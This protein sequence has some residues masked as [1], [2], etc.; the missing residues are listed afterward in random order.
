MVT[1]PN[2]PGGQRCPGGKL[3]R[4]LLVLPGFA[5]YNIPW[6]EA[7]RPMFSVVSDLAEADNLAITRLLSPSMSRHLSDAGDHG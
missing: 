5:G 4:P 1:D 6:F 2:L 3:A 7:A